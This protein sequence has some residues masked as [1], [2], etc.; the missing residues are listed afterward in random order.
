MVLLHLENYKHTITFSYEAFNNLLSHSPPLCKSL[1]ASSYSWETPE[2]IDIH[3]MMHLVIDFVS[4]ITQTKPQDLYHEFALYDFFLIAAGILC[5]VNMDFT[6]F[7][8]FIKSDIPTGIT[9]GNSCAHSVCIAS[10]FLHYLRM[11]ALKTGRMNINIS[12]L[13][14]KRKKKS[15][16]THE[17][18]VGFRTM[19]PER[20][21]SG[22]S[23]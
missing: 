22:L 9:V 21:N 20:V 5:S 3:K 6:P 17:E 12:K 7:S 18:I 11:K 16:K 19:K 14:P 2:L 15:W 4:S 13:H 10:A 23:P 8:V 1:P